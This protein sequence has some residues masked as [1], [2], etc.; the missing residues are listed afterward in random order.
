MRF[1]FSFWL[2]EEDGIGAE[3]CVGVAEGSRRRMPQCSWV[4]FQNERAGLSGWRFHAGEFRDEKERIMIVG[5][6]RRAENGSALQ[7]Q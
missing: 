4:E 1:E 7:Q 3:G 2:T 6:V 5:V